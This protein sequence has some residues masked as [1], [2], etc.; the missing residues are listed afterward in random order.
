MALHEDKVVGFVTTVQ[1]FAV[2]FEVGFIHL[3]GIAVKS[4]LHNKGIGTRFH[5]VM[6]DVELD[7]IRKTG[8]MTYI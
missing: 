3:T 1:S 6:S 8:L 7:I 4:E 2:V 5:K